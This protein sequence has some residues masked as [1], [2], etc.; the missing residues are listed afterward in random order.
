[1]RVGL[2]HQPLGQLPKGVKGIKALDWDMNL[3]LIHTNCCTYVTIERR[4]DGWW[5]EGDDA[6][7]QHRRPYIRTS[8]MTS[9]KTRVLN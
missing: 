7:L 5:L 3:E 2:D 4:Q 1:M 8:F 9:P 6:T